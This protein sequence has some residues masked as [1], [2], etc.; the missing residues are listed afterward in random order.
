MVNYLLLTES[1]SVTYFTNK[2]TLQ[3][4]AEYLNLLYFAFSPHPFDTSFNSEVIEK[5]MKV[6]PSNIDIMAN[7]MCEFLNSIVKKHGT[8]FS[9]NQAHRHML[10]DSAYYENLPTNVI[11]G[12]IKIITIPCSEAIVKAKGSFIDSLHTRHKN[13][14]RDDSRLQ[15]EL[16]MK[17]MCPET[18]SVTGE[19]FEL[20]AKRMA[21][22]HSFLNV[23]S[24][25]GP[26][27]K[28]VLDKEYSL[29]FKF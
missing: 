10:I 19:K 17:L 13:T 7:K 2:T 1:Y 20:I 28:K 4:Y 18:C 27:I 23:S 5:L 26:A 6:P 3:S 24:K 11:D 22:K 25:M 9:F 29:P 15:N 14:D 12:L 21:A 8:E 16:K